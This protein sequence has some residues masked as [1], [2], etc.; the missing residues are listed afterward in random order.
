M[1]P[2]GVQFVDRTG[3]RDVARCLVDLTPMPMHS[4]CR[5]RADFIGSAAAAAAPGLWG[6]SVRPSRAGQGGARLAE[7]RLARASV[8]ALAGCA[9]RRPPSRRRVID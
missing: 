8:V 5:A 7:W 4:K 3:L 9:A 2:T 1:P 6:P